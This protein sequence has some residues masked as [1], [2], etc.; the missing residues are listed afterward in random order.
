MH[1]VTYPKSAKFRSWEK[2]SEFGFKKK[3]NKLVNFR[4][5][6]SDSYFQ[7]PPYSVLVQMKVVRNDVMNIFELNDQFFKIYTVF[8]PRASE[9]GKIQPFCRKKSVFGQI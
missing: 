7:F 3:M 6:K 4:F 1:R 5:F 9:V 8:T 2:S